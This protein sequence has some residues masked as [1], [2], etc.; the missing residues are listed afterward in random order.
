MIETKRPCK[1]Y[2]VLLSMADDGSLNILC[3]NCAKQQGYIVE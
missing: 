3:L 2:G 1:N